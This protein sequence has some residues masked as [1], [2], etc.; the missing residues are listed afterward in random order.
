MAEIALRYKGKTRPFIIK[1]P[2]LEPLTFMTNKDP[3]WVEKVRATE[4]LTMNPRMFEVMDERGE[5]KMY[6]PQIEKVVKIEDT[7]FSTEPP[8]KKRGM[9]KGGWPKKNNKEEKTN[10]N[11]D[12]S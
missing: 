10:G 12:R 5:T 6:D 7:T 1:D 11:Q 4:L 8:K 3:V 2:I 9:P